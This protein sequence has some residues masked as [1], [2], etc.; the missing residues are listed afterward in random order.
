MVLYEAPIPLALLYVMPLDLA[1]YMVMSH[2]K[3][4][5]V[6]PTY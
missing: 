3:P 4:L 1:M 2:L 6:A 5:Y